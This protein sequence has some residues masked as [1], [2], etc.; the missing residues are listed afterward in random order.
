MKRTVLLL[1]LFILFLISFL[2]YRW[3]PEAWVVPLLKQSDVSVDSVQKAIWPALTLQGLTWQKWKVNTVTL[4]PVW[5]DCVRLIP[6]IHVEAKVFD[7]SQ[8]LNISQLGEWVQLND[9]ALQLSIQ[10]FKKHIPIMAMIPIEGDVLIQ[11]DRLKVNPSTLMLKDGS[12][13]VN[14]NDLMLKFGA[15]PEGISEV[16]VKAFWKDSIW[17]WVIVSDWANGEGLIQQML[18]LQH[19][20]LSGK[21]SIEKNKLPSSIQMF[22]PSAKEHVEMSITGTIAVPTVKWL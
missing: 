5:W 22:I 4:S 14:L 12:L 16:T 1:L 17:H 13:Q 21:V 10:Q 3:Q 18:P 15:E 8:V 9:T 6:A 2:W 7:L 19:S 20:T 11:V